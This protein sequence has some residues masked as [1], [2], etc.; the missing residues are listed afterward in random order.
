MLRRLNPLQ[1][2]SN[3]PLRGVLST[4]GA[5]RIHDAAFNCSC[6]GIY[7]S[8]TGPR[9][10]MMMMQPLSGAK[11]SNRECHSRCDQ[12]MKDS[13]EAKKGENLISLYSPLAEAGDR[14]A[15]FRLGLLYTL[16]SPSKQCHHNNNNNNVQSSAQDAP[17]HNSPID[18]NALD[19]LLGKGFV[20]PPTITSADFPVSLNE[21]LQM[22][23]LCAAKDGE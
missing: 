1:P 4:L 16:L 17:S 13:L 21:I 11:R 3:R 12:T 8:R 9:L 19:F 20:P 5:A 2:S 22:P 14:E 7:K 23:R 6:I 18:P 15:Q 10:M